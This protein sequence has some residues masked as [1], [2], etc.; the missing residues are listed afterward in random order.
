MSNSIKKKINLCRALIDVAN[1]ILPEI[2]LKQTPPCEILASE[3]LKSLDFVGQDMLLAEQKAN[4][5]LNDEENETIGRFFYSLG[6]YDVHN[7]IKQIEEFKE[8]MASAM[9]K[10]EE[11]YKSK[12][13]IFISVGFSFGTVIA[14]V[15]I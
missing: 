5:P 14:L 9:R 1:Y 12:S 2:K 13:K 3:R 15:L 10:Y 8:Y 11:E 6:K 4:T 7:Q